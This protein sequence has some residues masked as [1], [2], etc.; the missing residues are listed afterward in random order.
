MSFIIA[1]NGQGFVSGGK[2]AFRLPV[3]AADWKYF[4]EGMIQS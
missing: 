3:T 4:D 1:T 2:I